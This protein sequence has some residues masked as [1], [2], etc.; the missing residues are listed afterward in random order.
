LADEFPEWA[1]RVQRM[2]SEFRGMAGTQIAK[3][4]AKIAKAS[5]QI[6][7]L[8]EKM[9][10]RDYFQLPP[11]LHTVEGTVSVRR[12]GDTNTKVCY[13]CGREIDKKQ[14]VF[15]ANTFIFASPS[16]R[17]QSGGSQTQPNICG[18]CAALAFV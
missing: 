9:Q 15:Q 7:E 3:A 1:E 14:P 4:G 5:S 6:G 13:S 17:L 16:Q 2:R 8:A 10:N 11:L 12:A 18:A